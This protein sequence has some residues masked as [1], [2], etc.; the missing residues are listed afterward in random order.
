MC[1]DECESVIHVLWECLAYKV[2]R[3]GFMVKLRAILGEPFKD[4]EALDN[5]EKASLCQVVSFT[6][7]ISMLCLL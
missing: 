4:F 7:R 3:E 1:G 5:I 6:Q 2:K